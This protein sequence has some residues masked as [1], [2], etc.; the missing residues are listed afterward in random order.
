M[1]NNDVVIKKT[2][3]IRNDSSDCILKIFGS[4]FFGQTI[5]GVN[6]FIKVSKVFGTEYSANFVNQENF[7]C[8][9][10][11]NLLYDEKR[12]RFSPFEEFKISVF[13]KEI[14]NLNLLSEK[15]LI[16]EQNLSLIIK[17]EFCHEGEYLD[18]RTTSCKECEPNFFSKETN[19]SKPSTCL[20]CERL[21]F[22]CYGGKKLSPKRGFWRKNEN[23][24]NFI[25]CFIPEG[26]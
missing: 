22:F 2:V 3:T 16:Q 9:K 11:V 13:S 15:T 4:D 23:S 7:F 20:N 24:F 21:N 26:I 5:R 25:K 19:I 12:L 10:S 8:F 18:S 1:D 14:L 17:M 6:Y